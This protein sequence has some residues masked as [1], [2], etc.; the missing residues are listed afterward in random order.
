MF[1]HADLGGYELAL[2]SEHRY[3]QVAGMQAAVQSLQAEAF[4]LVARIAKKE[5]QWRVLSRSTTIRG[6]LIVRSGCMRVCSG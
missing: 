4:S 6:C 1:C 3:A 5:V 2:T